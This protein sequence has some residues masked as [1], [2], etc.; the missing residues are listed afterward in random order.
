[1]ATLIDVH[2]AADA[3]DVIHRAVQALVEGRLVAFPTE[4]VYGLAASALSPEGVERLIDVKSRQTGHPL[5]LAVKSADDALD[6]M[7]AAG[8][9]ERRLARRC[10]PGPVTLVVDDRHPESLLK[11]L[12]ANVQDAVAPNGTI[13]LRVPAHRLILEVLG[14]LAGPLTLTSANRA[15]EKEAVSAKEVMEHLGDVVELVLDDGEAHY[16]QASS[17]IHVQGKQLKMLREGVVT[18]KTARRLASFVVVLVCTGNTCRSPMAEVLMR[19]RLAEKLG[20]GVDE[21]EDRG[22]VVL[23]AGLAAAGGM[24]A[25]PEAVAVMKEQGL[26]LSDH[27]SQPLTER[28]LRDADYLFTMTQG[29]LWSLQAHQG[30]VASRAMLLRPDGQD[31]ADPIGASREMY[32]ECARQIDEALQARIA[33]MDLDRLLP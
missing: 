24:M 33:E 4:T 2:Q 16:G 29:H 15:G 21:L 32:A 11:Q 10:W 28:M 5:T 12:P 26:D 18:E 1:M 20:C 31:I 7:P 23:S 14:L 6:Y 17:V 9:M 27:A 19:K 30:N 22:V 13:G 8:P 25:S 3:R